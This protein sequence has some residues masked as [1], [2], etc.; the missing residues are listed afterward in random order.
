MSEPGL[1]GAGRWVGTGDAAKRL[2]L[3][4]TASAVAVGAAGALVAWAADRGTARTVATAYYLAGSLLFLVGVAPSGGYSLLR[5]TL[6]RRRPTGSRNVLI[7][8]VGVAL[9]ALGLLV[10]LTR[11]I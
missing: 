3:V 2:L 7:I 5:G 4:T 6:T 8:V 1:P 11:P 10:D 9:F